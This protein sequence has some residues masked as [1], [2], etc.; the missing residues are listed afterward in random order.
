MTHRYHPTRIVSLSFIEP[1]GI[2]S[3]RNRASPLAPPAEENG[4]KMAAGNGVLPV[5]ALK[6]LLPSSSRHRRVRP[7]PEE[8]RHTEHCRA[9]R[10]TATGTDAMRTHITSCLLLWTLTA[11]AVSRGDEITV[12]SATNG[13][14]LSC[15]G[16]VLRSSRGD[17]VGH[18]TYR[19][20][21]SGEYT[22]EAESG[23]GASTGE[24]PKIYVKFRTCENC[25]HLDVAT[26][27][28]LVVGNVV[29]TVVM[30]VAVYLIASQNRPIKSH[31]KSSDKQL[32][33]LNEGG[34]A[35]NEPYQALQPKRD[36]YDFLSGKR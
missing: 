29:A 30:G 11:A 2:G 5:S 13:V 21:N 10:T 27:A 33:V 24:G 12:K 8:N 17:A 20:D 22:C 4:Q 14:D 15:S 26:I 35:N 34:G 23:G 32:L 18:L 19:D 31:K 3:G 25:I 7:P 36:T 1:S 16:G 28:G 9:T 6:H